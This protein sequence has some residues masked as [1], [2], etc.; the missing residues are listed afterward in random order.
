MKLPAHYYDGHSTTPHD[1]AFAMPPHVKSRRSLG[2]ASLT[3]PHAAAGLAKRECSGGSCERNVSTNVTNIAIIM[4]IGI[5]VL[6][7][8][9]VLLFL[10]RRNV[11]RL[12][13]EDAK[14]PN[15]GLDFG[16]DETSPKG[17]KGAKRKS[18][19]GG[20]E[21]TVHKP[22]QLSMDMNLSSPYLLPPGI[23]QSHDSIHSLAR[24]FPN[25]QDPYRTIKDFTHSES[26]S[27]RSFNPKAPSV[28][29]S[30]KRNSAL[31]SKS[32]GGSMH[33]PRTNTGPR[34]PVSPDVP[35]NPF[36]TPMAPEPSQRTLA[37]SG[38]QEPIRPIQPIVPEIGTVAY[39]DDHVD[40]RGFD[41]PG[42]HAQS[43]LSH[44]RMDANV[45]IAHVD[46]GFDFSHPH[47]TEPADTRLY[48]DVPMALS[49]GSH[50]VAF[51]PHMLDSA[52]GLAHSHDD[53]TRQ[54]DH[55]EIT[56]SQSFDQYD[57]DIR[58]RGLERQAPVAYDGREQPQGLG[59][60]QQQSKRLSVG[61]RPLPP[62]EV[63][64]SEDPEYRA[65]RI[66][67]FYKEYFEDSAKEP[68][69]PMP[70]QRGGPKYEEDYDENFLGDAAYFD[71]ETNAF[72]MPYAQP[73]T[74]R[75]MT[76]PPTNRI[77]G[78]PGGGPGGRG[79]RGPH[80]PHGSMGGMG[81]RPRAGSAVTPRPGSSA[82]TGMRG[83]PKK[84]LPPPTALRTL[85]TP[86]KL[87]DDSFSIMNAVDFAPPDSYQDRAAG[88]SQ[89]PLGE[90][91]AYQP[92]KPV[93]SPLVT[94]FDELAV[95][96]S[97]HSLRK[98]TTFTNLDFAPPKKFKDSDT[99][100]DAG[101]I[102]SNRSGISA[103]QLGAIRSGAGRVSRLPGDT[104][105]T[106]AA[107]TDQLKPSWTMRP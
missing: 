82:S 11:R 14:D 16:L 28:H 93:A 105:F 72:V 95:L 41:N 49:P 25:E 34:S 66:R 89:S 19:F 1:N 26:G 92:K 60:P 65:N 6:V 51:E 29:G 90:R 55:P 74:R 79:P 24:T 81:Y 52:P 107:M 10:H 36:A 5:P 27:I 75:A 53:F 30:S 94:A 54:G 33:P 4:G 2:L 99:T 17:A 87:R 50:A 83:T 102:R 80:G 21:K 18:L 3:A 45:S 101:S 12:R 64:E 76:P 9:I 63:T 68:P 57:D 43:E 91:R 48:T 42:D 15:T 37:A 86:S 85:P 46:D 69:P 103:V 7:G 71:V 44:A 100:S 84:R 78:G 73:V 88:R 39:P 62:N 104:V 38:T 77:R 47:E 40:G 106:T 20:G 56:M 8:A 61:F 67:S 35:I 32:L 97:P 59:V 70:T 96:P 22:G 98:S 58:G 23:Q 31:T 13:M